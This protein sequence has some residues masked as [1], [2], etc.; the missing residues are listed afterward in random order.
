MRRGT[1][2]RWCRC[3]EMGKIS[4]L[5]VELKIVFDAKKKPQC[6]Q[7]FLLF[8]KIDLKAIEGGSGLE[9]YMF[10]TLFP[11]LN[12]VLISEQMMRN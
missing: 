6:S 8:G 9:D 1:E 10:L 11:M 7:C 3:G 2:M 4:I 12:I 5:T